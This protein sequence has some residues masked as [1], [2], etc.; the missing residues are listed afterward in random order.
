MLGSTAGSDDVVASTTLGYEMTSS[1]V[2]GLQLLH[3]HTY[4]ASVTAVNGGLVQRNVTAHSNG[5]RSTYR[6]LIENATRP[7]RQISVFSILA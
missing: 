4:F 6:R 5:R 2:D 1:C 3:K 7:V